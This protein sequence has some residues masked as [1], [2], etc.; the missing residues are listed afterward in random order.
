[1]TIQTTKKITS[2]LNFF[3]L[4]IL[5]LT[6]LTCL[7]QSDAFHW[8]SL[9]NIPFSLAYCLRA[10]IFLSFFYCMRKCV[11][12]KC[13]NRI[14][15]HSFRCQ[16]NHM[17]VKHTLNIYCNFSIWFVWNSFQLK[18]KLKIKFNSFFSLHLSFV[19][20]NFKSFFS[21]EQNQRDL[22]EALLTYAVNIVANSV[23]AW[24]THIVRTSTIRTVMPY[25]F[26]Y[27]FSID[28]LMRT[29]DHM[30]FLAPIWFENRFLYTAFTHHSV[31]QISLQQCKLPLLYIWL[32]IFKTSFKCFGVCFGLNF[33]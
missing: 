10:A 3:C 24:N 17:H 9:F 20:T 14:S 16:I 28:H 8:I 11:A 18:Q 21:Y 25:M 1:M 31:F 19:S 6:K 33:F 12:L 29:N 26:H 30:F 23:Q 22:K 27:L 13:Q 5:I 4:E 15:N 7:L 32:I 2:T